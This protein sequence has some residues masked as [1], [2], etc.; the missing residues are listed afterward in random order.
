MSC[1]DRRLKGIVWKGY[2]GLGWTL[3]INLSLLAAI[4]PRATQGLLV[5]WP[6]ILNEDSVSMP[7]LPWSRSDDQHDSQSP[8]RSY[9]L[10]VSGLKETVAP[11]E[12]EVGLLFHRTSKPEFISGFEFQPIFDQAGTSSMDASVDELKM[13]AGVRC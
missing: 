8:P 12:T 10:E 13:R 2:N 7:V 3:A 11:I 5:A 1:E 6:A 4:L 9:L